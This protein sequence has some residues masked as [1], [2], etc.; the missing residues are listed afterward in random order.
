MRTEPW[1]IAASFSCGWIR[2]HSDLCWLRARESHGIYLV[3]KLPVLLLSTRQVKSIK[4]KG[5]N[6]T[7]SLGKAM[8]WTYRDDSLVQKKRRSFTG[9]RC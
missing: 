2:F 6:P 8:K 1:F 3:H 9:G 5:P 7:A 4:G